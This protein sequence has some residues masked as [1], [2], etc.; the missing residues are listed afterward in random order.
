MRSKNRRPTSK[1]DNIPI[2][3][4][5]AHCTYTLAC[6]IG[7][8]PKLYAEMVFFFIS[9]PRSH[10][11]SYRRIKLIRCLRTLHA[12]ARSRLVRNNRKIGL[13]ALKFIL[14]V[15]VVPEK[16]GLGMRNPSSTSYG[17]GLWIYIRSYLPFPEK[18]AKP[19]TCFD[20]YPDRSETVTFISGEFRFHFGI[21][22]V[23]FVYFIHPF[24]FR[25]T[26]RIPSA[27]YPPSA[28]WIKRRRASLIWITIEVPTD[29]EKWWQSMITEI[30]KWN[31]IWTSNTNWY[32]SIFYT[33]TNIYIYTYKFI[34]CI[35]SKYKRISLK[36]K[37]IN[38]RW[39]KINLG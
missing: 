34:F 20:L 25:R 8:M 3:T 9:T 35:L 10:P 11:Y 7:D 18:F 1:I 6:T 13:Q 33:I 31:V 22:V 14:K 19:F 15:K 39:N 37:I 30:G 28:A 21:F 29:G 23:I 32:V 2:N 12:H 16:R 38:V 17:C 36:I 26:L 4:K 24:I 27:D 5:H